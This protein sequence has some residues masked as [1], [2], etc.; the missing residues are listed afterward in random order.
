MRFLSNCR[1]FSIFN[2]ELRLV[3]CPRLLGCR[4]IFLCLVCCV[5]VSEAQNFANRP[6]PSGLGVVVHA[7]QLAW[8]N[9]LDGSSIRLALIA[10]A[11]SLGD[12]RDLARHIDSDLSV[13]PLI[14]GVVPVGLEAALN[15]WPLPKNRDVVVMGN[16][17]LGV[18]DWAALR[19]AAGEAGIVAVQFQGQTGPEVVDGAKD[20]TVDLTRGL[21]MELWPGQGSQ[22]PTIHTYSDAGRRV[23]LIQYD[24]P[25]PETQALIPGAPTVAEYD[26]TFREAQWALVAR[27]V[28]WAAGREPGIR[29]QSVTA[30]GPGG[31]SLEDVPPFLPQEYVQSLGDTV[32]K[33]AMRPFAVTLS[34]PADRR[35]GVRYRARYP[36]RGIPAW[37]WPMPDTVPKNAETF[38]VNVPIGNG[39]VFL[40]LWLEDRGEIVDWFSAPLREVT[41]PTIET[42]RCVP[43]VVM[44]SGTI[45]VEF[46]V[47][48]HFQEPRPSTAYIRIEDAYGRL[49]SDRYLEIPEAGGDVAAEFALTDAMGTYVRAELYVADRPEPPFSLWEL[50]RAAYR[51]SF[52]PL[53]AELEPA[54]L[55]MA[56]GT[57]NGEANAMAAHTRLREL[58]V[59]LLHANES[60]TRL[61]PGAFLASMPRLPHVTSYADANATPDLERTPCLTEPEFI[62]QDDARIKEGAS[63][64]WPY[65]GGLYSLGDGNALVHDEA[66]VCRSPT[67]LEGFAAYLARAYES[68]S[69]L[70]AAWEQSFASFESA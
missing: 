13:V 35:Y 24:A 51:A 15:S 57:G 38:T 12:G 59:N 50:E 41:W 46:R 49:L 45:S 18:A 6:D 25:A 26:W 53:R 19:V 9:P 14:P 16:C 66:E 37:T 23:A 20:E 69:A 39:D 3:C 58:G 31:P 10:P 33:P 30:S 7:D 32:N 63:V 55:F 64:L 62:E 29:I 34:A 2:G 67:C 8:G 60:W 54:F 27:A 36:F 40:D 48:A 56:S 70:N 52:V 11:A 22:W 47:R 5:P 43:A 65:G 1:R 4:T 44:P 28:L 68:V 42:F 61:A 21:G 17:N